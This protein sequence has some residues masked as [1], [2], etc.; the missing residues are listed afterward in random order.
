VS[1]DEIFTYEMRIEASPEIVFSYFTDPQRM[2]RWMGISH[3]LRGLAAGAQREK[4]AHGWGH[5]MARLQI[6]AAGGDPG[7]DPMAEVQR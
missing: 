5:F 3:K 7:P 6:A 2:A 1:D 4:D